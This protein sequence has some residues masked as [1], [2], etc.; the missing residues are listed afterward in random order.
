MWTNLKFLHIW[1]VC[2]VENASTCV[3]FMFFCCK[4]G[5]VAIYALL[6]QIS[7]VA[8][9]A[10]LCGEK[11]TKHCVCGEKMTNIKYNSIII[12]L[13]NTI[14]TIVTMVVTSVRSCGIFWDRP[15]YTIFYHIMSYYT[16]VVSGVRSCCLHQACH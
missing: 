2:D 14:I 3:K 10:L 9:K 7:F 11:I 5:F 16:M 1:H 6:S 8:I 13:F 12:I 15:N 4:I